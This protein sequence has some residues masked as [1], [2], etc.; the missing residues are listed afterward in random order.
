MGNNSF[1]SIA[2]KGPAIISLNSKKILICN[3]LHVPDLRNLLYSLRAHQCQRGCGHI[4]MY[5]L[6]MNIF[7]PSFIIEVD[8]ATDCHLR[9]QPLGRTLGLAD[10]D[11]IQPKHTPSAST[12]AATPSPPVTIDPDDF[13]LDNNAAPTYAAHWPKH[14]PSPPVDQSNLST[15]PAETKFTK[16]LNEMS[17]E[18]LFTLLHDSSSPP[19]TASPPLAL[20][21]HKAANLLTCMVEEDIVELLHHPNSSLPLACHVIHLIRWTR[22]CIGWLKNSIVLLVAAV[23]AT[24]NISSWLTR[25]A[26]ILTMVNSRYLLEL[27]QQ[28]LKLPEVIQ[29]TELPPNTWTLSILTS[30]S[31]TA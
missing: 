23:F 16:P 30:H 7:F 9:Y 22:N 2:G 17:Q 12:T 15:L 10:L 8:I 3:C 1:A 19:T 29:L 21:K 27:I 26:S 18:E 28:S 20:P 14:P 6:G 5:G 4:G 13:D 11:Y 24:T 25:M 31:G